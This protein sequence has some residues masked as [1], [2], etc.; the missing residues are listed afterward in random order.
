MIFDFARAYEL[1]AS[2][3]DATVNHVCLKDLSAELVNE[4]SSG[5]NNLHEIIRQ[6]DR[7]VT[8]LIKIIRRKDCE[9]ERFLT[10]NRDQQ[11]SIARLSE[12]SFHLR[13]A[14]D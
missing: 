6:K 12:Y 2:L 7:E 13:Q 10:Y 8:N 4:S 5:L 11:N 14:V 1:R 3:T 9:L